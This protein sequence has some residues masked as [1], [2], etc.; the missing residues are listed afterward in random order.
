MRMLSDSVLVG[1]ASNHRRK[2]KGFQI[3][4]DRHGKWRCYH[5]KTRISVDCRLFMPFTPEFI[6]ECAR[7]AELAK[8]PMRKLPRFSRADLDVAVVKRGASRGRANWPRL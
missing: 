8:Q 7:V 5:R 1:G 3:F 4:A 2:V 6:L